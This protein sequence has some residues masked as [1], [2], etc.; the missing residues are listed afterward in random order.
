MHELSIANNLLEIVSE[1]LEA[2]GG[3]RVTAIH[4]QIG[5]LSCVHQDALN[6]SFDLISKGTV[7]EEAKLKIETVPVTI[8]CV[9]CGKEVSLSGIQNFRCPVCQTPSADIRQGKELDVT[10][11]EIIETVPA[12]VN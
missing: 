5:A 4:L 2:A 8:Y 6:F 1:H 3:G 12:E 9:P 11:I 7:A 10:S